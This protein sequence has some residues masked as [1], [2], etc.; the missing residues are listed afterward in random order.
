VQDPFDQFYTL[1]GLG[2]IIGGLIVALKIGAW[3]WFMTRVLH[4]PVENYPTRSTENASAPDTIKK[5]LSVVA[6][7]LGIISTTVGL[8]KSCGTGTQAQPQPVQQFVPGQPQIIP[9]Q[10]T[11]MSA[12]CCTAAGNC[13]MMMTGPVGSACFCADIYGNMAQG[14]VCQ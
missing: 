8:T 7:V 6:A 9:V 14:S 12:I 13:P 4:K 3:V 5:W 10:P 1:I 11:T 2:L